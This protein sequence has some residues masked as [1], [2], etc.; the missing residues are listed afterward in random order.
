MVR[1]DKFNSQFEILCNL[2]KVDCITKLKMTI[3]QNAFT[4]FRGKK[5]PKSEV[6]YCCGRSEIFL[7]RIK[8]KRIKKKIEQKLED[9]IKTLSR[10]CL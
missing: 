2:A 10:Y 7:Y 1:T 4:G 3:C 6:C 5:E 8:T 9:L